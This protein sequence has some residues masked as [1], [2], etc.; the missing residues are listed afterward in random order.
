MIC[1]N[2]TGGTGQRILGRGRHI[3]TTN[4]KKKGRYRT[5]ETDDGRK[6]IETRRGMRKNDYCDDYEDDSYV[7]IVAI[8]EE[9]DYNYSCPGTLF[10]AKKYSSIISRGSG[11]QCLSLTFMSVFRLFSSN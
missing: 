8:V 9:D 3:E 4:Q 2:R 5:R 10:S 7:A 1:A 11:I 6:E